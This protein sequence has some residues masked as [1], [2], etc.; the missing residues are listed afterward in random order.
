MMTFDS[1]PIAR[2]KRMLRSVNRMANMVRFN[3]FPMGTPPSPV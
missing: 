3:Q 2:E 1:E